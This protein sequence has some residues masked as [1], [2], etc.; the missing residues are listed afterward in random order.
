MKGTSMPRTQSR[1]LGRN[2]VADAHAYPNPAFDFQPRLVAKL[3][4]ASNVVHDRKGTLGTAEGFQRFVLNGTTSTMTVPHGGNDRVLFAS[5]ATLN[6]KIDGDNFVIGVNEGGA[7]SAG[8]GSWFAT[9]EDGT[10][11][12]AQLQAIQA[13]PGKGA[14][15]GA[16]VWAWNP[17]EEKPE[18]MGV[19]TFGSVSAV[20]QEAGGLPVWSLLR[21]RGAIITNVA[22]NRINTGFNLEMPQKS[23]Y[24]SGKIELSAAGVLG[25]L[26]EKRTTGAEVFVVY[27][28]ENGRITI[29]QEFS[30]TRGQW[31]TTNEID[32][33]AAD[34][35][36]VISIRYDYSDVANDPVL[37]INGKTI[38]LT[39]VS[40]PVGTASTN[41]DNYVLY[42]RGAGDRP[43]FGTHRQVLIF[44]TSHTPAQIAQIS[45]I[46]ERMTP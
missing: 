16:K 6:Y 28:A 26:I 22:A 36:Y 24:Y 29:L 23:I 32:Y 21:E 27:V 12:A 44:P 38:P 45:N 35:D 10:L 37:V 17:V 3:G 9:Y 13:N 20:T 19:G 25:R 8:N 42:N 4:G 34:T 1:K 15:L 31:N 18:L 46:L 11:T 14:A 33:L 41:N 7:Y 30:T 40:T 39:E 2:R 5:G 43:L